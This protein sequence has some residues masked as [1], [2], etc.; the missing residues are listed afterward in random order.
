MEFLLKHGFNMDSLC[1]NGIQYLSRAEEQMALKRAMERGKQ[2]PR[3]AMDIKDDDHESLEFL[4]KI[5]TMITDWLAQGK[6]SV[7]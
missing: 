2:I 3:Q 4:A 5:R 6:V 7:L 1:Q